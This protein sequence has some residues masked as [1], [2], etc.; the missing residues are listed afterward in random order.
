MMTPAQ[1]IQKALEGYLIAGKSYPRPL[2]QSLA[3]WYCYTSDGGHSIVCV[4]EVHWREHQEKEDLSDYLI[5]IP[6]KSVLRQGYAEHNGY[7]VIDMPYDQDVGLLVP[8]G[9]DEW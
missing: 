7:I 8:D 1:L 6:V 3:T 4:L 2:P 9:D 5:P